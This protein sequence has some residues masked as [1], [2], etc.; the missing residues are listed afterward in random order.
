MRRE[1]VGANLNYKNILALAGFHTLCICADRFE[2][3]YGHSFVDLIPDETVFSVSVNSSSA[4]LD[5]VL[6][7]AEGS[8][9]IRQ[10]GLAR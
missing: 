8:R 1:S 10:L 9:Y 5:D 4:T 6:A 7:R 3:R 2:F